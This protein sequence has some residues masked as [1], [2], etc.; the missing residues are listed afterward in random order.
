MSNSSSGS[1]I[2]RP[3]S[4]TSIL[5]ASDAT[6]ISTMNRRRQSSISEFEK[7]KQQINKRPTSRLSKSHSMHRLVDLATDD[8]EEEEKVK[9][10]EDYL[11]YHHE[12][13]RALLSRATTTPMPKASSLIKRFSS[14]FD[15]GGA[16][17]TSSIKTTIST[18]KSISPATSTTTKAKRSASSTTNHLYNTTSSS[19]M[20]RSSSLMNPIDY[21]TKITEKQ[22]DFKIGQRVNV[23]SLCLTGTVRFCGQLKFIKGNNGGNSDWV[24][25]ELDKKGAGKNDGSIQGVRYFTCAK[26]TGLFILATKVT[27]ADKRTITPRT[28]KTTTTNTMNTR[29]TMIS[30]RNTTN[31]TIV[32]SKSARTI[33]SKSSNKPLPTRS[34]PS[35]VVKNTVDKSN[36]KSTSPI[37]NKASKSTVTVAISANRKLK[38][39]SSLSTAATLSSNKAAATT[40]ID[41]ATGC[42]HHHVRTPSTATKRLM[43]S[44]VSTKTTRSEVYELKRV[45]ALLEI[46]RKE[47]EALTHQIDDKEAAWGRLLSAK[48]S[49]A[50]RVQEKD[51]EIM[52]LKKEYQQAQLA[53]DQLSKLTSEKESALSRA[54]MSEAMEKQHVKVIERLDLRVRNLQEENAQ[55]ISNHENKLRDSAAQIDQLRK[56]LAERD[57]VISS[58]EREC[59]EVKQINV[60]NQRAFESSLAKFKYE[61]EK[62]IGAKEIQIQKLEYIVN[63]LS[64]CM[65]TS[66]VS[67]VVDDTKRR[68]EAQLELSTKELDKERELIKSLTMDVHQLKDE[69]KR[70]HRI[71]ASSNLQFYS[72][73]EELENEIKDKTRIMEER[74][75]A[76]EMQSRLEEENERIRLTHDKSQRDLADVL[77]K[78]AHI[79]KQSTVDDESLVQ[80]NR[81]L[82]LENEKLFEAQKQTEHECMRLMDELLAIEKVENNQGEECDEKLYRREIEQL[83][84]QV[85]REAKRYEDLEKSKHAKVEQ[86]SK[87]LSDLESLVEKKV[88]DETELEEAIENEKRKVRL[89]ENKLRE[90]EEKNYQ[91]S[92]R[93][94]HNPPPMSPTSPQY[95]SIFHMN[96]KRSSSATAS[97]LTLMTSSSLDT[98]SDHGSNLLESVYCEICEEY[99]HEVIT[100]NAFVHVD[101][102]KYD[103]LEASSCYCVNCDIFGVHPTEHCPNQDETF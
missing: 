15:D 11:K 68:L 31:A 25:I 18:K 88:F 61:H 84:L 39:S 63:D 2:A 55:L 5:Q 101:E 9:S 3:L 98:V 69:I 102:S 100:C 81:E 14:T 45:S 17:V 38:K 72:L 87:E 21:H 76:L 49:Y 99:G 64:N 60:N 79:E 19:A 83:K 42:L 78:L 44:S 16:L 24:G 51:D 48:E 86:L 75:A 71:S 41:N 67:P 73:R 13:R 80:R 58:I 8:D 85:V 6:S 22:H 91:H 40:A 92:K 65:P 12:H 62:S 90:E 29:K 20:K 37:V 47:Q 26:D 23:P 59:A 74:N 93:M 36:Q 56:Q 82:E 10:N 35:S 46:S 97:S 94:M 27:I 66:P 43:R 77:K 103:T 7:K 70:L 4:I 30:Q 1:R 32:P 95:S 52:R 33:S 28:S 50:V 53:N 34:S 89:L 54:S 57:E 96:K